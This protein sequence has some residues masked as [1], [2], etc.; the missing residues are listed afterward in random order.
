MIIHRLVLRLTMLIFSGC[1]AGFAHSQDIHFT[2]HQMTPL[3]FNPANTGA[4]HGSYRLSG[5]Y[6]DQYRSITTKGAFSTPTFSV[7]A[8]IIRGFKKTDW[9]GVGIFFY[10]DK[11]GEAG[12]T[13][14]TFK[15]SA[16]YHLAL[17]KSGNQVLTFAYQT[18]SV[19]RFIKNTDKLRFE[20]SEGVVL[21]QLDDKK[22]FLD[23]VA[24]LRFNS[25]FNKTDEWFAGLSV[26]H[27]GN[28]DWSLSGSNYK[29][30]PKIHGQVGFA[31]VMSD[32][33]KFLPNITYQKILKSAASTLVIQ[34]NFDYLFN[35]QKNTIL[36]GGLG[37]RSGAGFG[38][39]IQVM[40]GAQIKEIVV[41]LG[42]DFN[43]SPLSAASGT[44]GAFEIA[45]QYVGRIYK[46]P[47]PDPVIFCPRF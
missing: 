7:D 37:Y 1:I 27:I 42:Y 34:G 31:T 11:S 45:A 25:K 46:R 26:G 8:P 40:V 10:S 23:H 19:Q 5:L 33:M 9:V 18:G 21:D 36:K 43:L 13:Q 35:E 2:L 47:N 16:A 30:E 17:S 6:R 12:L 38:D 3:A 41:M 20:T 28:P 24:G 32:K 22:G 14:Q 4:F 29:L 44:A 39:A 15:I